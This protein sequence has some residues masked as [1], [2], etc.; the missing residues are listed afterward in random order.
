MAMD[1]SEN[2][3]WYAFFTRDGEKLVHFAR[4][5]ARRIS[6]MDAEDIVADVMLQLVSRLETNGPVENIAAYAYRAV[7][8][9]IADYERKRA[10][11]TS[12]DGMAD[13]DG[14]LPLLSMLA[15]E[16]EEPF[17]QE[18]RVERMH[19]L[20]DAIGKLEPRQRAILIATELKGK[21]FREL[22][23][24]WNEPIGTLLSRKSRAVKALRQ[25]LEEPEI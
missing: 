17:A 16:N 15:A 20:T 9:K 4:N 12:L 14:E 25:M 21:S 19:R 18:E 7:R 23:E 22:A 24:E 10:K 2:S 11:E 13:A 8:N 6:E 5:H 3:K 1:Q